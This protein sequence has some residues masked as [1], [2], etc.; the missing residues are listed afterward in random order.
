MLGLS[1][2]AEDDQTAKREEL[3]A[4]E[5]DLQKREAALEEE[6]Q[7]NAEKSNALDEKEA[8][9]AKRE[10]G[11]AQKEQDD[12]TKGGGS[13]QDNH[14]DRT[15]ILDEKEAAL[16]NR[17]AEVER[18]EKELASATASDT[19]DKAQSSPSRQTSIASTAQESAGRNAKSR[20]GDAHELCRLLRENDT[21]RLKFTIGELEAQLRERACQH[22]IKRPPRKI[23]HKVEG[24]VYR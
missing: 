2:G 3:D 23:N 11:L 24:F 5:Q 22:K 14:E 8:A 12:E 10:E 16:T 20:G 1:A 6:K 13:T 18:R 4:K 17:E 21:L 19:T 15:N 9:L 7:K